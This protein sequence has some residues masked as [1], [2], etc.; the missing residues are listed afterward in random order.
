MPLIYDNTE[1]VTVKPVAQGSGL[2]E[3]KVRDIFGSLQRF[4]LGR[5]VLGRREK[6]TQFESAAADWKKNIPTEQR[7]EP[8]E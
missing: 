4:K 3:K 2:T 8:D 7:G 1:G 6:D 5:V